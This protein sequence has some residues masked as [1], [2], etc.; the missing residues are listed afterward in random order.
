MGI[1]P[2]LSQ[3]RTWTSD[4]YALQDALAISKQGIHS[5]GQTGRAAS[6]TMCRAIFGSYTGL[7]A[8]SI[9]TICAENDQSFQWKSCLAAHSMH[10]FS[11]L[12]LHLCKH[13]WVCF[14]KIIGWSHINWWLTLNRCWSVIATTPGTNTRR[15][16]L[17]LFIGKYFEYKKNDK[18][19]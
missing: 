5:N 2:L 17:L 14:L 1:T 7:S 8:C 4:S 19:T 16:W 15:G 13:R 6:C 11:I 18:K 12:L 10:C 3:Y 9:C